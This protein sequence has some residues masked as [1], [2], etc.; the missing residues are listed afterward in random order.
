MHGPHAQHSRTRMGC[1]RL[2]WKGTVEV[3]IKGKQFVDECL[4]K[5]VKHVAHCSDFICVGAQLGCRLYTCS[6]CGEL[7]ALA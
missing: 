1:L 3:C 4:C 2:K 7:A 6:T 5:G